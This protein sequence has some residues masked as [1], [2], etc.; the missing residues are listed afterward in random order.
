[1]VQNKRWG[2]VSLADIALA[3][4]LL[5]G[6]AGGGWAIVKMSLAH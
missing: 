2:P 4:I 1:M 6:V 3:I 5:L